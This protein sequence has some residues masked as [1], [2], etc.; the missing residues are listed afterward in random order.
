MDWRPHCRWPLSASAGSESYAH[1]CADS[2]VQDS[3]AD[4]GINVYADVDPDFST[5]CAG[6]DCFD[7]PDAPQAPTEGRY[8]DASTGA[9][10]VL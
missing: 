9:K 10:Y 3:Y 1:F 2:G 5:N 4:A 8:N 6:N 7:I